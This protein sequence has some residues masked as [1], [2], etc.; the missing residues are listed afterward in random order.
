MPKHATLD[1]LMERLR[2]SLKAE[3]AERAKEK[4][5]LADIGARLEQIEAR[6]GLTDKSS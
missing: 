6:L 2:K 5:M 4:T 3:A 1:E